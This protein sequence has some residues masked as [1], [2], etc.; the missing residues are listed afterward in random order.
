MLRV[1][2]SVGPVSAS[3]ATGFWLLATPVDRAALLRPAY[4][5]VMVVA[6]VGGFVAAVVVWALVGV[7]WSTWARRPLLDGAL[8]VVRRG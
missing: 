3:R 7:A 6:A 2:L 5:L 8:L 1:L 4:R